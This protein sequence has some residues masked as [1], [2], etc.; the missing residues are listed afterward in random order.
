M[1]IFVEG[2]IVR[3]RQSQMSARVNGTA[4]GFRRR[5]RNV[6][7]GGGDDPFVRGRSAFGELPFANEIRRL[8]QIIQLPVAGKNRG[9][10]SLLP[11]N[12]RRRIEQRHP[13]VEA[14]DR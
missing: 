7:G 10:I 4:Q 5:V 8:A 13:R 14:V 2:A 1:M 3:S 6:R 11:K 12:G 9:L